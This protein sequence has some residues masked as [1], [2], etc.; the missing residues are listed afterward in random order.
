VSVPTNIDHAQRRAN[1]LVEAAKAQATQEG[2]RLVETAR[3]QID[4][5]TT[6]ARED[7]RKDV[8]RLAVSSA[9]KLLGREIDATAHSDLLGALAREI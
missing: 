7:L 6:K 4:L 1:E 2:A 3:A 5:A 8:A 9:S